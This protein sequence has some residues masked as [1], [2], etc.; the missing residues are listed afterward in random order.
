M[1][2]CRHR[3]KDLLTNWFSEFQAESPLPQ[4]EPNQGHGAEPQPDAHGQHQPH[5]VQPTQEPEVQFQ[6]QQEPTAELVE[7]DPFVDGRLEGGGP[8]TILF[9]EIYEMF[10]DEFITVIPS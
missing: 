5:P 7:D 9:I 8:V 4:A 2:R 1:T 10:C 6:S 3:D